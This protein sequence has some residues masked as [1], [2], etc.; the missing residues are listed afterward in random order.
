[1]S[2]TIVPSSGVIGTLVSLFYQ[3]V[4]K[5]CRSHKKRVEV[6]I[7]GI[8]VPFRV[9]GENGLII[10]IAPGIVPSVGLV[11]ITLSVTD[12][13]CKTISVSALFLVTAPPETA[14]TST[15]P[16]SPPTSG[17]PTITGITTITGDPP[18]FDEGDSVVLT[19]TNLTGA[20]FEVGNVTFSPGAVDVSPDGT[21]ATFTLPPGVTGS[22]VV[23]RVTNPQGSTTI[24]VQIDPTP[25]LLA[26][27]INS[28]TAPDDLTNTG[29]FTPGT[30]VQ[31]N[32]ANFTAETTFT[33]NGFP[34]LVVEG[35]L[36]AEGTQV[37]ISLP[38][39]PAGSPVTVVATNAVGSSAPFTQTTVVPRISSSSSV[40][41][42]SPTLQQ[43]TVATVTG[44]GFTG[45]APADTTVTLVS[46][47][48]TFGPITP[49][50]NTGIVLTFDVP[51]DIPLG[52]AQLFVTT[53]GATS[54]PFNVIIFQNM[55]APVVDNIAVTSNED[56]TFNVDVTGSNFN[57]TSLIQVVRDGIAT[58]VPIT[59]IS[60]TQIS[61]TLP[62][63]TIGTDSI[64]V[65]DNGFVSNS[66]V[67]Q[68]TLESI[69][70]P[71]DSVNSSSSPFIINSG[72][73]VTLVGTRFEAGSTVEV[74]G[75][76]TIISST[77]IDPTQIQI[78][79][80]QFTIAGDY[81]LIVRNPN[82]VPSNPIIFYVRDPVAPTIIGFSA[83]TLGGEIAA[84]SDI[85]LSGTDFTNTT[86]A[87]VGSGVNQVSGIPGT[88]SPDGTT[89]TFT[90]PETISGSSVPIFVS[91][92]T[93]QSNT[94]NIEI[95]P[96]V[97]QLTSDTGTNTATS[98][99]LA[100]VTGTGFNIGSVSTVILTS[101]SGPAVEI[102]AVST[103]G[104]TLNFPVP[105]SDDIPAGPATVAVR[106]D[107]VTSNAIAITI[108]AEPIT[109]VITS[110][111]SPNT[112]SPNVTIGEVA[113][114]TGTGFS[115]TDPSTIEVEP[116]SGPSSIFTVQSTDGTTLQ[117]TFPNIP[118]SSDVYVISNGNGSAPFQVNATYATPVVDTYDINGGV[119][120]VTGTNFNSGS[121]IVVDGDE[122]IT[123]FTDTGAG[124]GT[125]SASLPSGTLGS[126][127]V[128]VRN[129]T[130]ESVPFN[131]Q[132][133]IGSIN[134]DGGDTYIVGAS[135][136]LTIEGSGFAFN[137]ILTI[138]DTN[139]NLILQT[140]TQSSPGS[141]EQIQF[142][143]SGLSAPGPF[144]VRV[145]D[146]V[147]GI[148][149]NTVSLPVQQQISIATI[150]VVAPY[151][152]LTQTAVIDV[153]L[154]SPLPGTDEPTLSINGVPVSGTVLSADRTTIRAT[155]PVDTD[156]GL[157]SFSV[158]L[159]GNLVAPIE[160]T[161]RTIVDPV[162]TS[163]GQVIAGE[164][165]TVNGEN[166]TAETKILI[167][168]VEATRVGESSSPATSIIVQSPTTINKNAMIG[169]RNGTDTFLAPSIQFTTIVDPIQ[170][171][172]PGSQST[173]IISGEN[174]FV[175]LTGRGF[176]VGPQG[177]NVLITDSNGIES[178][179]TS[180]A[181]DNT[182]F[183]FTIPASSTFASGTGSISVNGSDPVPI[184]IDNL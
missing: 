183:N 134:V 51:Q 120:T 107:G 170:E 91:Q 69:L 139:N 142:D 65:A 73:N 42:D 102:E 55:T 1:M 184:F 128:V 7:N 76:G 168:G 144:S 106:S 56:G 23:I 158:T 61:G 181:T 165:F 149:S 129:G 123:S 118:G 166:F 163:Y 19:G 11:Q 119:L 18:P 71:D 125:L 12:K 39:Q 150:N 32:G 117:F 57:V 52:P 92:G 148:S 141:T 171:G 103:D 157:A 68:P 66:I 159:P 84:G 174:T 156:S 112:T 154:S 50:T 38:F 74:Q 122:L 116:T 24:N 83:A 14:S 33:V 167:D 115:T 59:F 160:P 173:P 44:A 41:F 175:N 127:I 77:F 53:N 30:V 114:I 138:L 105:S 110:V 4:G 40:G 109:P 136:T 133:V 27:I 100:T 97:T 126:S 146:P 17:A 98:G 70:N 179:Y 101:D 131:I 37:Q 88:A 25:I 43:G 46:G 2:L 85:V 36:N 178:A 75:T 104:T 93:E 182:N 58:T 8:P 143:V 35:T 180:V 177:N 169:V 22:S 108:V 95:A 48:Q 81:P 47:G 9:V 96:T 111:S 151:T 67:I 16:T 145:T 137:T 140:A 78:D 31:V 13:C 99:E 124:T 176:F 45:N 64:R 5:L 80:S 82:G 121:V 49:L 34:A 172:S 79:G 62:A 6:F 135:N 20:T 72:T 10:I 60:S 94:I 152:A 63:G 130:A 26:P 90:L 21:T 54:D 147:T 87:T 164:E 29:P 113:T 153:V 161:D 15:P 132:P 89:F 86:T 162:V 28:I 155:I 3:G